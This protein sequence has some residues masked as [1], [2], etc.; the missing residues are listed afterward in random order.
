[1]HDVY[2]KYTVGVGHS[3]CRGVVIEAYYVAD[4]PKVI[5]STVEDF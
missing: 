3:V 5:K 1:M 2:C 4:A